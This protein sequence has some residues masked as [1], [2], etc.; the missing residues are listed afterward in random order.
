MLEMAMVEVVM[1]IEMEKATAKAS[2]SNHS[3]ALS[4]RR[5]QNL[6]SS[7][8]Q[9]MMMMMM[10]P[11]R[12]RKDLLTVPTPPWSAKARRR[13]VAATERQTF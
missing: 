7:T 8:R 5:L 6:T 10:D 12:K 2:L 4:R 13:G 11:W 3:T 1:E 9:I